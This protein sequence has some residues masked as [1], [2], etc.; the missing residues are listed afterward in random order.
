M[1]PEPSIWTGK[2]LLVRLV[3]CQCQSDHSDCLHVFLFLAGDR[4]NYID[5]LFYMHK[6]IFCRQHLR[7]ISMRLL[8]PG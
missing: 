3:P 8:S 7:R 6:V 1:G 2:V 4:C 5:W